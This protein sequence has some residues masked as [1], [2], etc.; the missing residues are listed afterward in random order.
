[1]KVLFVTQNLP[2]PTNSGS[3]LRTRNLVNLLMLD[4]TVKCLFMPFRT[5]DVNAFRESHPNPLQ[6]SL[7][8]PKKRNRLLRACEYFSAPLIARKEIIT[9][10]ET[11][12][13]DFKPELVWI[14]YLFVGQYMMV[15]KKR[16]LPVIYG[17]HNAQ[18]QLTRQEAKSERSYLHKM[19][20]LCMAKLH[21][22]HERVFLKNADYLVCVSEQDRAFYGRF[23]QHKKLFILPN[24]INI[25]HYDGIQR[26][27]NDKPY[28]CFV[29]SIDNF[30]NAQ[31]ILFFLKKIWE[32]LKHKADYLQLFI[33]GRGSKKNKEILS[34]SKSMEDVIIFDDVE[35]VVPFIKGA[36]ASIV[37]LLHGSGTR[38]KIIESMA[39]GT[40]VISTSLGAEG[41]MVSDGKEILFADT[42][43]QFIDKIVRLVNSEDL[44]RTISNAA[45]QYVSDHYGFNPARLRVR[46]MVQKLQMPKVP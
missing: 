15:F 16:G 44:R 30:Q 11:L 17:T 8:V 21:A 10:C 42:P 1:M 9:E 28:I 12:L 5:M 26:Y 13:N 25:Q 37:P 20:Y 19:K 35:S 27:E 3:R 38:L 46:E 7:F 45:Y 14:D 4:H 39:C 31:G 40:P 36:S 34:L 2:Y 23:I 22:I 41:I 33:V 6:Y 18:S 24:F 32:R 43:D 29:G